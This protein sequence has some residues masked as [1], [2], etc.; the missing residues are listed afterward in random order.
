MRRALRPGALPAAL[1]LALLLPLAGCESIA[2]L[3]QA[4]SGQSKLLLA[5]RPIEAV[6][7]DPA[8]T[9]E[10]RARLDLVRALRAYAARE[11]GM[12]EREGFD[13]FAAS[14]RRYVVW[15]VVAA[16]EFSVTP[17]AWCFPVAGC[18][19][20]RGYFDE[21]AARRFADALGR[22][23][24]ETWVYGVAAYSTLGWFD[25]PVLDTWV[26][27]SE[28]FV[29]A[30]VF[31]ELAHQVLYVP[32]DTA[33]SESFAS[34]VEREGLRRWLLER[35]DAAA[36]ADYL[37]ERE[38]GEAVDALLAKTREELATLYAQTLSPG[39]MR[40]L[41][42]QRFARLREEYALLAAGWAEGPRPGAWI[43]GPLD[44]ARLAGAANY[45]AHTARLESLLEAEG[46]DLPRF[47]AAAKALAAR[48]PRRSGPCPRSLPVG[49]GHA[50][51]LIPRGG[52]AIRDPLRC[53]LPAK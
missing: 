20:Y 42:A 5:R 22:E 21:A 44:N 46:G 29:A 24:R 47:Y 43:A 33:F 25:D 35:G 1:L 52:N 34:V 37:L 53:S 17:L 16:P 13:S 32:G 49:A 27:R 36:Y 38:R 14:G 3:A 12:D 51:E 41:K 39:E 40:E 26:M 45:A 15:N 9:P 2:Y 6:I 4:S 28:R 11:L 23:G 8:S 10:L 48:S 31:H 7:A 50:R 19:S 18:V 30:L